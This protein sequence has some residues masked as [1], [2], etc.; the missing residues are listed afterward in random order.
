VNYAAD[1]SGI[2]RHGHMP[3]CQRIS[4]A[5]YKTA[6]TWRPVCPACL[7]VVYLRESRVSVREFLGRPSPPQPPSAWRHRIKRLARN[8]VYD[9]KRFLRGN[10]EDTA[11]APLCSRCSQPATHFVGTDAKRQYLPTCALCFETVAKDAH[12][13]IFVTPV[14]DEQRLSMLSIIVH[15]NETRPQ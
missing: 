8:F 5:E 9:I 12:G 13:L 11:S 3:A 4:V 14:A 15:N 6:R 7:D 10:P 1:C 2:S